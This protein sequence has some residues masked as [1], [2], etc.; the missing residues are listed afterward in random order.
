MRLPSYPRKPHKASGLAR[1]KVSGRHYYFGRH[2]TPESKQ[3]FR[4]FVHKLTASPVALASGP[5]EIDVEELVAHFLTMAEREKDP[6]E[7]QHIRRICTALQRLFGSLPVAEFGV[8]HLAQLRAAFVSG[9][10]ITEEEKEERARPWCRSHANHAIT[11]VRSLW[12]WAEEQGLAPR[13]SWGHLRTLRPMGAHVKGVRQTKPRQGVDLAAVR[14]VLPHLPGQWRGWLR[15]NTGRGCGL[16]KRVAWW[17]VRSRIAAGSASAGNFLSGLV[18]RD[19]GYSLAGGATEG[20]HGGL[21]VCGRMC[22]SGLLGFRLRPMPTLG[23]VLTQRQLQVSS[24]LGVK[25]LGL[26]VLVECLEQPLLHVQADL[27]LAGTAIR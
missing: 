9:S 24:H 1:V 25:L 18:W 5:D 17:P 7:L 22:V 8:K 6:R 27:P 2:G 20:D 23:K 13:G 12:R 3:E 26:D 21:A 15:C 10:W 16:R 14:A 4:E 11:R 19:A